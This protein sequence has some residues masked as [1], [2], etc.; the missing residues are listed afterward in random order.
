MLFT[1]GAYIEYCFQNNGIFAI[2]GDSEY[3]K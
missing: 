2:A 1:S 3:N